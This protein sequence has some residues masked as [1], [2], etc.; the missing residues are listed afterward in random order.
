MRGGRGRLFMPKFPPSPIILYLCNVLLLYALILGYLL[1]V[2]V[3]F[4]LYMMYCM[5]RLKKWVKACVSSTY[6]IIISG[7]NAHRKR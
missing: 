6:H 2:F 1:R 7:Y 5:S 3:V 4:L